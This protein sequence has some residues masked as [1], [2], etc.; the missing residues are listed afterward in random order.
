LVAATEEEGKG[1]FAICENMII[2]KSESRVKLYTCFICGVYSQAY[3]LAR[4]LVFFQ[5]P[6]QL[7]DR[8]SPKFQPRE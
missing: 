6:A 5:M 4:R 8:C 2:C 3:A 7:F 1:R